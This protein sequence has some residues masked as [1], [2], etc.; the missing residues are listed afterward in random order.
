MARHLTRFVLLMV[1]L[2]GLAGCATP[3]E[4]GALDVTLVNIES[5]SGGGLGEA[6]LNCEVRLQNA[7][8]EAIHVDGGVHKIYLNG[9]YIGQGLSNEGV[10]VPR[11]GTATHKVTV[12]FS[13]FRLARSVFKIYEEHKADYKLASTLYLHQAGH[14]RTFRTAK[15]GTIDLKDLTPPPTTTQ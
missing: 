7:M 2:L 9:V 4:E 8:P 1:T 13:T 15:D 14:S 11:L 3:N 5:G 10:D 12:Y 6:A